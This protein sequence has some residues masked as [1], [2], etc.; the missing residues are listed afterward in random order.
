MR[1]AL[2][3]GKPAEFIKELAKYD[4]FK[5]ATDWRVPSR[6]QEDRDFVNRFIAFYLLGY[7]ENYE[8]ELDKFLNDGMARIMD[9][10]Q[11]I[12]DEIRHDFTG[13]MNTCYNIFGQDCFRKRYRSGDY[14]KPISK[15][16]FDT[17]S[18]NVARLSDSE[19]EL[20]EQNHEKFAKGMINLFNEEE[21]NVAISNSTG[22]K[23]RVKLR[24]EKVRNL[25]NESTI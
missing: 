4:E 16:V 17:V 18:V 11:S 14:R 1:H 8:G 9:L 13:A 19:R 25:I 15:A 7:E 2:N 21:F 24:F 12:L 23:N 10:E 22:Q 3:Q 5:R 6:R 20:L